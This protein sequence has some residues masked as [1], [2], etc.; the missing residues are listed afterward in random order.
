MTA[1][2]SLP[3][4]WTSSGASA[5]A[6]GKSG[7]GDT[8]PHPVRM[9]NQRFSAARDRAETKGFCGV[10]HRSRL[11]GRV[12]PCPVVIRAGVAALPVC[13]RGRTRRPLLP[14][15]AVAGAVR[16]GVWGIA[17]VRFLCDP[18]ERTIRLLFVQELACPLVALHPFPISSLEL[19][20][21]SNR[22]APIVFAGVLSHLLSSFTHRAPHLSEVKSWDNSVF[23]STLLIPFS[24]Y[25]TPC[26]AAHNGPIWFI[27]QHA[28]RLRD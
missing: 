12:P 8:L 1:Q 3:A 27:S 4:A 26:V 25:A 24:A 5:P 21:P 28:S 17:S 23:L 18:L 13:R 20:S 14:L 19:G 16:S 7:K 9:E 22:T 6:P 10:P 2:S 15:S 11:G